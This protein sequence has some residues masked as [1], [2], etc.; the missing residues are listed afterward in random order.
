[1]VFHKKLLKLIFLTNFFFVTYKLAEL[2]PDL[3]VKIPDPAT[4][5]G[6]ATLLVSGS[7]FCRE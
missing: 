3:V 7:L 6:S 5:S 2:D 4:K 1:M